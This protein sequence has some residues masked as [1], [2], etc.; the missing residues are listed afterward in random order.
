MA[1]IESIDESP[2]SAVDIRKWTAKD[3][4]LSKVLRY[5]TRGWPPTVT[6]VEISPFFRRR[7]ELSVEDGCI[8]WGARVLIPQPGRSLLLQQ[9]PETHSGITRMKSLACGFV[10]WPGIDAELESLV[11]Q[12]SI[13]QLHQKSPPLAP[14]HSWHWPSTSWSRIHLDFADPFMGNMF[15][16]IVDSHSKWIDA[17]IMPS[18]TSRSTIDRLRNVFATLGLPKV[19]V[20]DNG[21]S[22]TTAE[23]GCFMKE[24]GIVHTFTSPYHPSSNGLVERA[25]Q[26]VK[27]GLKKLSGPLETRLSRLL[28]SYRTTP[29]TTTGVTPAE[30]LLGRRI[31][32]RL[33]LVFPD[34]AK[35][36]N[37][38]QLQMENTRST[39]CRSFDVGD[40]VLCKNYASNFG[41]WI[42][43]IVLKKTGPYSYHVKLKD[44]RVWRKHIDQMLSRSESPPASSVSDVFDRNPEPLPSIKEPRMDAPQ[45][46]F[47]VAPFLRRSTQFQRSPDRFDPC[48]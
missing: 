20:S 5:V 10:W 30:L 3:P 7:D 16:L 44:G 42:P 45:E 29:H 33:D 18:I 17:H 38:R 13:C 37:Q 48:H 2:V 15:L 31:R 6:E 4:I 11:R 32:T 1:T 27:L 19:V 34:V 25:V 12:C 22:F 36:V 46:P 21:P 39:P 41:K 28:F 24:N 40:L 47:V 35:R 9:L 14:I 43:A 23:F 26:T 8:L